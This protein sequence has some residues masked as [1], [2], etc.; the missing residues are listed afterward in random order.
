MRSF[1]LLI[2]IASLFLIG[3]S[4]PITNQGQPTVKKMLSMT[5]AEKINPNSLYK[6]G[7]SI[8]G[9]VYKGGKAMYNGGKAIY[10]G[11]KA[12]YDGVKGG[13]LKDP[14]GFGT[15]I[16]NPGVKYVEHKFT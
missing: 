3:Q 15:G 6:A 9:A 16:L 8:F 4:V 2:V 12:L 10:K 11:S 14:A 13:F 7:S 1:V 5:N